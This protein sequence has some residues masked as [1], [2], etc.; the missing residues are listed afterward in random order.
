MSDNF[1]FQ[2]SYKKS[3]QCCDLKDVERICLTVNI[4]DLHYQTFF[5]LITLFIASQG[6]ALLQ[7]APRVKSLLRMQIVLYT[8]PSLKHSSVLVRSK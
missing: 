6:I 5:F 4:D 2:I 1:E 7:A 8:C 3:V